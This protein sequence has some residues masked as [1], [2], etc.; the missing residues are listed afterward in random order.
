MP[1]VDVPGLNTKLT[2]E[3]LTAACQAAEK[4]ADDRLAA[5]VALPSH[6]FASA[7]DA[8][9]QIIADYTDATTRLSFLKDIHPDG[10]V[11]EA[12]AACEEAAGKYAVK[13]GA[14]KDIYLALKGASDHGVRDAIDRRLIQL[15]MRDFKRNGL[16]LADADRQKLVELRQ[17]LTALGTQYSSNLDEDKTSFET[18]EEELEGLPQDFIEAHLKDK[19][20]TG[21]GRTVVLTTKYPD[22]YP[23]LENAKRESL[24]RRIWIAFQSRQ[25]EKNLPILTEAVSLRDQAAHLLGYPTHAD[26]VTEDRMARDAKTVTSFLERLRGE[27]VPARDELN[28]QMLQLKIA[29]THDQAAHLETWDWRYYL[30]QIKKQKYSIDNEAVR[31][32][33]P[34]DKVLAGLFQVYSTLLNVKFNEVPGA[35]VWA[36]GVKLYEVRDRPDGT[37]KLLA[38][39]YV[40]L[41]P[42]DGKYGHAASFSLGVARATPAGYQIPLSAL[43][44]NFSPPKNGQFARLSFQE[45]DVLFH[46]FGHIMHQSLTTARYASESGTNVSTDFV[47]APSQ[48]LENWV[49]QPEI[50]ALLT[51][52]PRNPGHPMPADLARR[53]SQARTF[54]AGIRYSR[55]VFLATFDMTLHTSGATVDPDA[56]EHK[57]RGAITGYPVHPEEHTAASF[58]HLMGGYDAGYYGYLWSEVYADDMFSRFEKEGLLNPATGRAYRDTIL[59]RGR[60]LE[61]MELLQQFLARKPNEEAFLRLTGIKAP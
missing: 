58:G 12:A 15:T 41:F 50:L 1:A 10:K 20:A 14:R 13:V 5:M 55:Q 27:L 39:F 33:F 31:Q 36:D 8:F 30:N 44:V 52:D 9:E 56:I 32:Y 42:R 29:D 18:T 3:Q 26:F 53:L 38:K 17:R 7:F 25:A 43:V 28:R 60:E 37:G 22:Y 61:P 35:E 47:E 46:E 51:E 48:M 45:V 4:T 34:A 2:P 54:D 40:D 59:A 49:Y 57:V 16:E 6:D 23:V 11:R 24:R 21:K 19:T